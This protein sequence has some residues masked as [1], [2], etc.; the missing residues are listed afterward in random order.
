MFGA[1]RRDDPEQIQS[2]DDQLHCD[3]GQQDSKYNFGNNQTGGPQA[4]CHLVDVGKDRIVERA[5][6]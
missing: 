6:Q 1:G 4:F 2:S 3:S 5:D